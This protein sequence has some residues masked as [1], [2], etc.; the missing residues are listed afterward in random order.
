MK[1]SASCFVVNKAASV[2]S[3]LFLN[4]GNTGARL[5]IGPGAPDRGRFLSR[6]FAVR[7]ECDARGAMDDRTPAQRWLRPHCLWKAHWFGHLATLQC[8][9][10]ALGLAKKQN[11]LM[12]L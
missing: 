8:V 7:R 6:I 9:Q 12:L 10:K 11:N 5:L 2:I 1:P 3:L 4:P